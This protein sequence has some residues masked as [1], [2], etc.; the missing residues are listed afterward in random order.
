MSEARGVG[1]VEVV[2]RLLGF[3]PTQHLLE[4]LLEVLVAQ[5]VQ[6]RIEETVDVTYRLREWDE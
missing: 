2:R 1:Q 3:D 6:K 5:R 4:R